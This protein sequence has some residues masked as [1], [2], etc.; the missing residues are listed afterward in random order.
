MFSGNSW[1]RKVSYFPAAHLVLLSYFFKCV[2]VHGSL[3]VCTHDCR[4]P[5]RTEVSDLLEFELQV[6]LICHVGAKNQ[7]LVLWKS[8]KHF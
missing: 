3:G 7:T 6:V 4:S 5:L 8:N 1:E 2:Y